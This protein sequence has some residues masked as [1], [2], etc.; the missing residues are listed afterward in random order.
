MK[1][2]ELVSQ[3][4]KNFELFDAKDVQS[5]FAIQFN[6]YG[7]AEGAFYV[8]FA[9]GRISVEPYEYYDRDVI[10]TTDYQTAL[11][12]SSG[13]LKI[14]DAFDKSKISVVGA[15]DRLV[16]IFDSLSKKNKKGCKVK[17]SKKGK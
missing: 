1:Y 12:I 13:D 3:V 7:E 11:D 9:D 15:Y 14:E 4:K 5:H 17:T 10:L 8:A 6:I 2:E 16:E